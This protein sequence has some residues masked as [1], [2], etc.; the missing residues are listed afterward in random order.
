MNTTITC[1]A[2]STSTPRCV[3]HIVGAVECSHR[4]Q[5][6]PKCH[7]TIEKNGGCNHMICR[8]N[9]CRSEFCWVCLGPWEPHGSSWQVIYYV[10][11]CT[12]FSMYSF[13]GT[14]AIDSMKMMLKQLVMHRPSP[15][16]HQRGIFSTAT[17]TSII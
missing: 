11:K 6:C 4:L 5:E 12:T 15:G 1:D 10:I 13:K 9:S 7:A 16:Q 2:G 14:T 17:A 8:N 3:G